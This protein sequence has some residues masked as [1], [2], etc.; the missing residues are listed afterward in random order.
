M[1]LIKRFS[2]TEIMIS[3]SI[4]AIAGIPMI[5]LFNS[6]KKSQLTEEEYFKALMLGQEYNEQL[7]ASLY[8][9]PKFEIKDKKIR[10]KLSNY[11]ITTNVKPDKKEYGLFHVE[12][13][14]NWTSKNSSEKKS[15]TFNR[16]FSRLYKMKKRIERTYAWDLKK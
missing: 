6:S 4:L 7:T 11:W 1:K 15:I 12:I 8:D 10:G 3:L 2:L 14:V 16:I 5:F 13:K 9:N